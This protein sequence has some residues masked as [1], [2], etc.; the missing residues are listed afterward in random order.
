MTN[1]RGF[2]LID[3]P[4]IPLGDGN[5]SI[6]EALLD[7]HTL[8]G[9]PDGDPGLAAAVMRTLTVFAYRVTGM[10]QP[11]GRSSFALEQRRLLDEGRF[12][13]GAVARYI[14]RH[15]DRFWLIGAPLNAPPF[16]QDRSLQVSKRDPVSK[17]VT[18][19]ASGHNPVLGPHAD[20]DSL[21]AATAAQRLVVL[22]YYSAGGTHTP[23]PNK[24][25]R[26]RAHLKDA[27]LRG[28]MSLHPHAETLARTLMGHLVPLPHDAPDFGAPFW[29]SPPVADP[30]AGHQGQAGLLEQLAARQD[31]TMLL[32][33]NEADGIRGF[34]IAEGPGSASD[35][36]STDPYLLYDENMLP[37]KP[38]LGRDFW[39]EAEALLNQTDDGRANLS[40]EIL[41]WASSHADEQRIYEPSEFSWAVVSHL[42]HQSV[43]RLWTLSSA[44]HL[45][46][47]FAPDASLRARRFLNEASSAEGMMTKQTKELIK[48][49]QA[50]TSKRKT[51]RR[52]IYEQATC[53]TARAE[54]WTRSEP[55]FWT[56]ALSSMTSDE[57]TRRLR[58]H[59]LAGYDTATAAMARDQRS[60]LFVE[61]CRR[62]IAAWPR[63][64][65]SAR[66]NK[67]AP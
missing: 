56:A 37:R 7:A 10:D 16:A 17:A 23:H 64:Q 32:H 3:D 43:E 53:E 15:R 8:P 13:A 62:W 26:G 21:D 41:K 58:S 33:H 20:T 61:E 12:D 44:P 46:A 57:Q 31:K 39:R 40:A 27:A 36:S 67:E 14:D 24:P 2:N 11:M 52:R 34:T 66:P 59:A 48:K 51:E 65:R 38:H 29:E 54:F 63:A 55:D 35:L 5:V 4:W 30:L 9:W 25:G 42:G 18:A 45:L 28:T 50:P 22:R 6:S 49:V 60:L 19:W 1:K 47:L